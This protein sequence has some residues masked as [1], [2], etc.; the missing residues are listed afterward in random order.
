MPIDTSISDLWWLQ[1]QAD[2]RGSVLQGLAIG[3]RNA[4]DAENAVLQRQ[5]LQEN[6]AYRHLAAQQMQ[7]KMDVELGRSKALTEIGAFMG[8]AYK[9][10]LLTDPATQSAFWALTGKHAGFLDNA[11]VEGLWKNNFEAAM[12]RADRAKQEGSTPQIRNY[13]AANLARQQAAAFPEDSPERAAKLAEADAL[14]EAVTG[15]PKLGT[16]F[17]Q[18]M[19][20]LG[21]LKTKASTYAPEDVPADLRQQIAM[22]EEHLTGGAEEVIMKDAQG[23]EIMHYRKGKQLG[24]LTGPV[25]TQLQQRLFGNVDLIN[26]ANKLLP[27]INLNTTGPLSAAANILV[28][29]GLANI[30]PAWA[31]G[32]RVTAREASGFLANQVVRALKVDSQLSVQE[33]NRLEKLAVKID[34]D[35]PITAKYKLAELTRAAMLNARLSAQRL[36]LPVPPEAMDSNELI[37]AM[38]AGTRTPGA[39]GTITQQQF[40]ELATRLDQ[41]DALRSRESTMELPRTEGLFPNPREGIAPSN[42][43]IQTNAPGFL[44]PVKP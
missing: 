20:E 34:T 4:R 31:S 15:H 27:Q 39:P 19:A 17:T 3:A 35:P 38:K 32:D 1:P 9:N 26:S 12:T 29:K 18:D 37:A 23:N 14:T 43:Q 33:V 5:Q 24:A 30:N 42:P 21:K 10:N 40:K 41:L 28:D 22:Y 36:G 13:E 25:N 8:N 7:N 2:N 6:I 44:P 11:T 16:S